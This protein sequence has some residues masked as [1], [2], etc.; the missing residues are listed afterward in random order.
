VLLALHESD[1]QAS[2]YLDR[3]V[4]H[5]GR[6][7]ENDLEKAMDPGKRKKPFSEAEKNRRRDAV[8]ERW[9]DEKQERKFRD[10]MK[11]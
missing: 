8:F 4:M 10:P 9:F 6:G 3:A 5:F 2:F 1:P 11:G 7:I